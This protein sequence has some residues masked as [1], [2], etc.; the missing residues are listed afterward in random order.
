MNIKITS[1]LLI[2]LST[3]ITEAA[4]AHNESCSFNVGW[5]PDESGP[6]SADCALG[7]CP[8]FSQNRIP[9][10]CSY[11]P[12]YYSMCDDSEDQNMTLIQEYACYAYQQ[13]SA[14]FEQQMR[15]GVEACNLAT[16][17]SDDIG[18]SGMYWDFIDALMGLL[19][20]ANDPCFC[21]A[22]LTYCDG[23]AKDGDSEETAPSK[24]GCVN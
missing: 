19:V 17:M 12:D 24:P 8:S 1:L 5:Y 16:P 13:D 20:D 3:I 14:A 21:A 4:P 23:C 9:G 10:M 18:G 15:D 6:P 11:D 22:L 2:A 7:G